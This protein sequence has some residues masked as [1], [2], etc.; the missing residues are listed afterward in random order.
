MIIII[1]VIIIIIIINKN[2]KELGML[3][4]LPLIAIIIRTGQKIVWEGRGE[5]QQ[6]PIP[7]FIIQG[8]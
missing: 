3:A 2:Y 6:P 1:I 4:T 8:V 7:F 5:E